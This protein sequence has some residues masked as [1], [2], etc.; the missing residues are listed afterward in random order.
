[1]VAGNAQGAAS[2]SP[3][4]VAGN[5]QELQAAPLQWLLATPRSCKHVRS[6]PIYGN[7]GH[8]NYGRGEKVSERKVNEIGVLCV[9]SSC[10]GLGYCA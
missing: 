8:D 9:A 10:A 5:A 1:M 4:M 2:S 6:Q 7:G 3:P